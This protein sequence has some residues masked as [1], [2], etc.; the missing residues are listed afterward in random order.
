MDVW[1]I[2]ASELAPL[3]G[4]RILDIGCGK[5]G[6]LARLAGAGAD[7][8]GVDPAAPATQPADGGLRIVRAGAQALPFAD[9]SFDGAVFVNSLHHVPLELMDRAL[10][11]AGRVVVR[12]GRI[13][14]VEPLAQGSFFSALIPIE[15]ETDVRAAAQDAIARARTSGRF[16]A[17]PCI[18]FVRH[19]AFASI[20][21]FLARV[22]D[23][24]EDRRPLV[25]ARREAIEQ[26]FAAAAGRDEHGHFTL[27]Q[28]I[29]VDTLVAKG[30]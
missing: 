25:E 11:E 16:G 19:D 28:P 2:I 22:L 17:G 5:G 4:R 14:V 6:M 1:T 12:G 21:P 20:E 27:D 15:D 10:A 13:V 9:E 29:R 8:T 23:A 3:P 7:A 30:A 24:D 18:D 26:A